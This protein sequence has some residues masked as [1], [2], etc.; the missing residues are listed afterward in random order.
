MTNKNHKIGDRVQFRGEVSSSGTL[1][2]VRDDGPDTFIATVTCMP[3]GVCYGLEWDN[4][5]PV[6]LPFHDFQLALVEPG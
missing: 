4:G 6:G 1:L 5:S 2:C 3:Y